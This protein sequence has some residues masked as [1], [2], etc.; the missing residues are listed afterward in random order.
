MKP[1]K[2]VDSLLKIALHLCLPH[3]P[4]P[5]SGPGAGNDGAVFYTVVQS[6]ET[7]RG[8]RKRT[9]PVTVL[10]KSWKALLGAPAEIPWPRRR[11]QWGGPAGH[12]REL[13]TVVCA[14][15]CGWESQLCPGGAR[16]GA[17]LSQVVGHVTGFMSVSTNSGSA[18]SA[19]RR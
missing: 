8:T 9:K 15:S 6:A 14:W 2:R 19:L 17:P 10:A 16:P 5:G 4:P 3:P 18:V 11:L 13:P 1:Q 7:E 12:Q